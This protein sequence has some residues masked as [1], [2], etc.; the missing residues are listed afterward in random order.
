M[1]TIGRIGS[2]DVMVF[3]NDHPPPHFHV[4]GDDFSAKFAIANR[5]LLSCKGRIRRRDIRAVE[6]WGQKHQ[7]MLYIN[8]DLARS[9]QPPV[10]IED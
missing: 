10:K 8:W 6:E 4:I 7:D 3:R 2:L 1:P 9:G 5:E